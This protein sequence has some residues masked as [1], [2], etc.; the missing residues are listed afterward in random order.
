M[1]RKFLNFSLI[2]S[3][4]FLAFSVASCGSSY[5]APKVELA[6]SVVNMKTGDTKK[7]TVRVEK[8]YLSAPVYWF[9][10]NESVAYFRDEN[11]GYLTAVGEGTATVTAMVAGGIARCQVNVTAGD[12]DPE[13]ARFTLQSKATVEVGNSLRLTYSVNP[14]GSTL[15][16]SS[17]DKSIADVDNSGTVTG[18]AAGTT[19]ITGICSNGLTA[20]CDV[21]VKETGGGGGGGGEDLDIGVDPSEFGRTG[22]LVVGSPQKSKTT[23]QA[24]INAFNQKTNSSVSITIKT[25][26]EGEGVGNFPTGA[27]SGPD[28]FPFVSDQTMTLNSLGALAPLANTVSDNY[29]TTMLDGAID[30]ASWND[31]VLGYPFAADN[32]VVMF[33]DSSLVSDPSEIDTVDKLFAKA[34]SLGK[35]VSYDIPNSFYAASILHTFNE[36]KSMFKIKPTSTSYSCSST[37]ACENGVKGMQLAYKIMTT[38]GWQK[39]KGTPGQTGILATIIDTSNVREFKEQMGN[40]YAVAPVPY[41][42]SNSDERICTYLGY[43]FYGVNNSIKDSTKK[44]TAKIFAKFLVSEYAQNYRFE[45]EKTQPTLRTLQSIA[46]NEP[47]I[48]ALNQQKASGSTQLL[49]VFGDEY[50]NNTGLTVLALQ[51][52]YIA[53]DIIPTERDMY[54]LLEELDNSWRS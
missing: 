42:D 53:L 23:M 54:N 20:T 19:K 15:T 36:G 30:A 41:V 48:A 38:A 25:F 27:A 49:S 44:N 13:A 47:H 14:A 7:L 3:A 31:N 43:K 22:E 5:T 16:F 51:N 37:F 32:G 8:A 29:E 11:L 34:Q 6:E 2:A 12:V 1:K 45:Q 52:D 28:V 50:F 46:Q 26:E 18:L 4:G 39:D 40:K 17:Q 9:T 24:L 35:S 10:S 33:Y 21:T